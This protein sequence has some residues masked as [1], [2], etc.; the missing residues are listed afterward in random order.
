MKDPRFAD[1]TARVANFRDLKKILEDKT[2]KNTSEY[3]LGEFE[4][5]NVPSGPIND[6]AHVVTDP[7]V[8]SRKMIV[9]VLHPVAGAMKIPGV[10]IK[11]SETPAEISAPA[12]LLG[13]HTDEVLAL[14]LGL[15]PEEIDPQ[16]GRGALTARVKS[17]NKKEGRPSGP[18]R[19]YQ[20]SSGEGACCKAVSEPGAL[21]EGRLS[22]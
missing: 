16:G 2:V 6:M 8:L 20:P 5:V 19:C 4:K 21:F 22:R 12:P 11:F 17:K 7:Q 15:S 3:W 18:P 9:D 13:Q 1:N 10:P 14:H